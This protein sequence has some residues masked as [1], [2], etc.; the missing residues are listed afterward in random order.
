VK[1]K[2]FSYGLIFKWSD[3]IITL[4]FSFAICFRDFTEV[5]IKLFQRVSYYC[6]LLRLPYVFSNRPLALW[7]SSYKYTFCL[8]YI[9]ACEFRCEVCE[10]KQACY[11]C[12]ACETET[13]CLACVRQHK[14]GTGCTGVRDKTAYVPM[15]D[16][17]DIHLL[18]GVF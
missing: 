14:E 1:L 3:S 10:E 4:K 6:L 15:S 12:P 2:P 7:S 18:N 11:R 16:L 5:L 17:G 13:C 8:F 9:N